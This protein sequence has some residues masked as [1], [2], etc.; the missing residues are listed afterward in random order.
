MSFKALRSLTSIV[1]SLL[2]LIKQTF[3]S[4]FSFFDLTQCILNNLHPIF[5]L[6]EVFYLIRDTKNRCQLKIVTCHLLPFYKNEVTSHC[7]H[8]PSTH[9]ERSSGQRSEM[10][11]AVLWEKL[12]E[13]AFGWLFSEDFVIPIPC[14]FSCLENHW[15]LLT[16]TTVPHY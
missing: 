14:I 8:W 11:H 7:C 2:P 13:Q 5:C 6:M 3:N 1:H 15:S 10:R 12:A 4:S 9:P 16:E